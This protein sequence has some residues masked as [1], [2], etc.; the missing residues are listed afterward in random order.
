LGQGFT[1]MTVVD[2]SDAAL[3]RARA[4]LGAAAGLVT[5]LVA[6]VR[7]LTL[8][9]QVDLWHDRAVFHFLTTIADQE[10]YLS[11][12][13][14]AVRVGGHVVMATFAAGG[15]EKCSG[16]LVQRY[17]AA[18]LADRLGRGFS[19]V[20]VLEKQHVTPSGAAQPFTYG[21]FRRTA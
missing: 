17:D 7:T 12:L 1:R 3:Q 9:E 10:S 14:R 4:R 16:L 5:W 13:R 21:L 15:P 6:D 8:A 2:I 11:A 19:P 20:R 18:A